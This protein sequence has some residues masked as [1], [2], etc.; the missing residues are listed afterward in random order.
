MFLCALAPLLPV[1][2]TIATI[3]WPQSVGS[4]GNIGNVTAPLVA[5]APR[6]L[7]VAIPC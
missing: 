2:Q 4:D 7:D 3:Q 5:G 6:A 1:N